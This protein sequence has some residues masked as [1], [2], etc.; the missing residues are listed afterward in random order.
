[1]TIRNTA[2]EDNQMQM[3]LTTT[4]RCFNTGAR[5]FLIMAV[6]QVNKFSVSIKIFN[7]IPGSYVRP[8]KSFFAFPKTI[9]ALP[10][11][12]METH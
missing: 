3:K 6:S 1:M 5:I 10:E 4:I 8:D 7:A 11:T 2:G 9:C 12:F